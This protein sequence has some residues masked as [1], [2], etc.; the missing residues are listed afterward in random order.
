MSSGY[1]RLGYKNHGSLSSAVRGESPLLSPGRRFRRS[2]LASPS[3]DRQRRSISIL[4]SPS[5]DYNSRQ[6]RSGF[7]SPRHS[8]IVNSP[9][10]PSRR[11]PRKPI[12]RLDFKDCMNNTKNTKASTSTLVDAHLIFDGEN[13]SDVTFKSPTKP[14]VLKSPFKTPEKGRFAI[15]HL[16]M[17]AA[18]CPPMLATPPKRSRSE[19]NFRNVLSAQCEDKFG[20]SSPR[21]RRAPGLSSPDS[22]F[23]STMTLRSPEKRIQLLGDLNKKCSFDTNSP[24]KSSSPAHVK[25]KSIVSSMNLNSYL[26]TPEKL[27]LKPKLQLFSTPNKVTFSP[28]KVTFSPSKVVF[29]KH[30]ILSPPNKYPPSAEKSTPGKS[31]LKKSPAR[32]SRRVELTPVSSSFRN[33]SFMEKLT[34]ASVGLSQSNTDPQPASSPFKISRRLTKNETRSSVSKDLFATDDDSSDLFCKSSQEG[35]IIVRTPSPSSKGKNL[36]DWNRRKKLTGS[37]YSPS[38]SAKT[39]SSSFPDEQFHTSKSSESQS[40]NLVN[41]EIISR[42]L[43]KRNFS[44]VSSDSVIES[45]KKRA[46]KI[47]VS[48]DSVHIESFKR[49][50]TSTFVPILQR[51]S[52][53]N[54]ESEEAP[55]SAGFKL[56]NPFSSTSSGSVQPVCSPIITS[57]YEWYE[58]S[59][60]GSKGFSIPTSETNQ[61]SSG[62]NRNSTS[63]S[64]NDKELTVKT[65]STSP[66]IPAVSPSDKKIYSPSL[67]ASGLM[68]LMKSPLISK[69]E[70]S[71]KNLLNTRVRPRSR[72]HLDL[73]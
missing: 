46:R 1:D 35:T 45:P 22:R 67:T 17:D 34:E 63:V 16:S 39:S 5:P 3:P 13:A 27:P 31:I 54:E 14:F 66:A 59:S 6:T 44:H 9:S 62:P 42:Q 11:S 57:S 21:R 29:S 38:S 68:H 12:K 51:D 65:S 37:K 72:K 48:K 4:A 28:S 24:M 30:N 23:T 19:I 60:Q 33:K 49:E 43:K 53:L 15:R 71:E 8:A 26:S 69:P 70:K 41:T 55:Y 58:G 56:S 2:F 36:D 25:E 32:I 50:P 73:N 10:T 18:S 61:I 47:S 40:S 64:E 20:H 52:S 7:T